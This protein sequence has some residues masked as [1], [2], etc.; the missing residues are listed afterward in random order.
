MW[1]LACLSNYLTGQWNL[2][3]SDSFA[4]AHTGKYPQAKSS[5]FKQN[6]DELTYASQIRQP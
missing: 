5:E 4:N 1:K 6:K 2:G 3:V